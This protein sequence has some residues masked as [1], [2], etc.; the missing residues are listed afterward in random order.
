MNHPE[1]AKRFAQAMKLSGYSNASRLAK[2]SGI[3]RGYLYRIYNGEIGTPHKYLEPLARAMNVS[4]DWLGYGRGGPYDHERQSLQQGVIT[5]SVTVV[6]SEGDCYDIDVTVPDI[7]SS[8]RHI[9]KYRETYR[10]YY[11]PEMNEY[12]PGNTLLTV[13]KEMKPGPGLVLAWYESD[14]RK[15]LGSF[16]RFYK[17]QEQKTNREPGM[18][19]IGRVRNMDYW[20][21]DDS[22]YQASG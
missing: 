3:D 15:K 14:G 6:P 18:E 10:F 17:D 5:T 13:E 20:K 21:V 19:V 12:F 1:M 9:P 2:K 8:L 16:Q 22:A 11:L 7:F 4:P